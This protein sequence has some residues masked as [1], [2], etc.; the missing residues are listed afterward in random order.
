MSFWQSLFGAKETPPPD[1]PKRVPVRPPIDS[2][3]ELSIHDAAYSGDL[4]K[5]RL[6]LKGAPD[7]ASSTAHVF[8]VTPLHMAA[9]KGHKAVVELLVVTG[10]KVN[11]KSVTG[12]T[13]LH[14]AASA[15][16]KEVVAVLLANGADANAKDNGGSTAMHKAV[17]NHHKDVVDLLLAN[18]AE[19]NAKDKSDWSPLHYTAVGYQD[20]AE[21]L[22]ARGA[23]AN[24]K[25]H[26]GATPL[27]LATQN[28]QADLATLMRQ[29]GGHE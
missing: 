15:G 3:P 5:I 6:L 4:E 17:A 22:L 8:E 7:L 24:A 1:L 11:A 19:V 10:T 20:V 21:L 26:A 28:G 18:G 9:G 16:H 14:Y 12:E 27:H 2:D 29:H 25:N 13:P 23:D